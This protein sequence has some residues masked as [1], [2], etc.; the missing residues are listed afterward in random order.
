MIEKLENSAIKLAK[1]E[2]ENAWREMA[3]Q[4]AHE[5]K[6]P[7]T[8]MRL[9][10]QTFERDFNLK[11]SFSKQKIKDFSTSLI[12]QIDTMSSIATAF[13]DFAEMP[14]PKK[15]LL[16]ISEIVEISLDIFS[17]KQIKFLPKS[18]KIFAMFDRTQLIRIMT[19]LLKNA[20]QAIPDYR[21]PEI[22]VVIDED[23]DNV[24]ISI[25]DNG[26]GISKNDMKKIFEPSFTTK[27]SG[28]GLGLS[29]IK[30]ILNAYSGNIT[31]TTKS[32]VGTTFNIKFPKK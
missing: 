19:N 11:K 20:F 26:Y 27:T 21:E 15:E 4:V 13:S 29:M 16:N 1:I 18:D 10:I 30:S 9:T 17:K 7:L 14:E 8:P 24:K 32:N 22:K 25:S 31:F 28:M 2:R 12:Q 3:K 6:N 23:K 5:I